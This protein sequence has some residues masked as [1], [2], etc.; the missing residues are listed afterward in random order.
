[1][2]PR[3][4]INH[5]RALRLT[6]KRV[7]TLL[8]LYL[9]ATA[10]ESVAVVL[11]LPAMQ[12][13]ERRGDVGGLIE[14]SMIWRTLDTAAGIVGL[15]PGLWLLLS[16]ALTAI[17]VRQ[18][19]TLVRSIY[20]TTVREHLVRDIRNR[21]FEDYLAAD[22]TL[23]DRMPAGDLINTL[24]V[25]ARRA[26]LAITMPIDF[27]AHSVILAVYVSV[28]LFISGPLTL[29][30][31]VVLALSIIPLR[32][33]MRR[34]IEISRRVSNTNA[35]LLTFLTQRVH[36]PRLVRLSGTEIAETTMIHQLTDAQFN[37]SVHAG[38]VTAQSEASVEPIV[39][40]VAFV[41]LYVAYAEFNMDLSTISVF[42][43]A[44]LRLMPIART[45]VSSRQGSLATFGGLEVVR[46]RLGELAN[47]REK[48]DGQQ[49]FESV[50]S[51]I[52]F[53][54]V[55]YRYPGRSVSALDE[56]S[57]VIPR[58]KMTALVG[59]S[60][61]GKSTL[62]DLLPRLREPTSGHITVGGVPLN[63]F[64]RS[65]LRAHIAYVPQAPQMFD[66]TMAEHIRYGRADASDEEVHRAAQL[67][68]AALFIEALP[69]GYDTAL[70]EAGGR[71]SGGQRQ[72]L[73]LAR[74]FVRRAPVVILD[75]PTSQLDADSEQAFRDALE[76][77][78]ADDDTT[79]VVVAH[80][81]ST[82][83][84]A[85]QI[86]VMREGRVEAAGRH[87]EILVTSPWYRNAWSQQNAGGDRPAAVA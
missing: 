80:R 14:T 84:N 81:L 87:E 61:A 76:R 24:A 52:C 66:V 23:H 6:F 67:A 32:P 50:G 45:L 69:D 48:D 27:I 59:P 70:G 7:F 31:V 36:S 55:T 44:L 54:D 34:A 64:T 83:R 60:G 3:D 85:D 4:F 26:M 40:T 18:A 37:S 10:F 53:D 13:I 47:A 25:E 12:F 51:A 38:Y 35:G 65:S 75:E 30:V 43:F 29:V 82:I 8:F 22:T 5:A 39:V 78:R 62:I 1:M 28:L 77:L 73:D 9:S 46:D 33:L 58:G 79:I 20:L 19:I 63:D 57:V 42:L 71:L 56:M 49:I 74:A 16:L 86:V 15:R 68:G 21:L 17:L 41:L 11:L 2:T 72:R